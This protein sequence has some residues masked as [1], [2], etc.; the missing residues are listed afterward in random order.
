MPCLILLPG[1][2]KGND[3][4]IFTLQELIQDFTLE[5]VS[6]AGAIFNIDKLNWM[7]GLY[8]RNLDDQ[9]YLNLVL[10]ELEKLGLD[11]GDS[12]KNTLIALAVRQSLTTLGDLKSKTAVFFKQRI[13]TYSQEAMSW[14]KKDES[15][16]VFSKIIQEL[17]PLKSISLNQFKDIMQR[18]QLATG[19]KGKDLWMPVRSA[20]TGL[21]EG[22]ELPMVIEI[23]GRDRMLA[24]LRQ[25]EEI[26]GK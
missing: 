13:E 24:F 22:P 8:L 1:W 17:E 6:K 5:R 19:I 7:N 20:M 25:A 9:I 10:K 3:Q 23:I 26:N 2:N 12:N 11:S 4:E 21:T 14:I 15:H 16:M 18:V